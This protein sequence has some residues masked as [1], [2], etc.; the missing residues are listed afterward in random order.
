MTLT[1]R[2]Q[3]MV[4]IKLDNG[5]DVVWSADPLARSID[6][7]QSTYR[8]SA[9]KVELTL[10]KRETGIK[11]GVLAGDEEAISSAPTLSTSTTSTQQQQ[12]SYPTSSKHKTNWDKFVIDAEKEDE[13]LNR[14]RKGDPNSFGGDRQLNELFQK[15]YAD[16]TDDQRRA[17][18]KSYQESNGTALST[19]WEDVKSRK[20]ETRPPEVRA[21]SSVR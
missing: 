12:H 11:W 20:V 6:P 9:P 14:E 7:S 1:V 2:Y 15:L 8:V 17:M 4:T 3:A 18:I 16:A 21:R 5:S 19:D 13:A 10:I